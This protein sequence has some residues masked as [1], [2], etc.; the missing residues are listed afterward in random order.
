[1]AIGTL[2]R[3]TGIRRGIHADAAGFFFLALSETRHTRPMPMKAEIGKAES[4]NRWFPVV[5]F[6]QFQLSAFL[7]SA[8]VFAGA[9]V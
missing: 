7:I 6:P 2:Q 4:R 5:G 9:K 8:F 1:M 3:E